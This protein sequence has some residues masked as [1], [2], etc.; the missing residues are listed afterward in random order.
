M[1]PGKFAQMSKN[2]QR[3]FAPGENPSETE[4]QKKVG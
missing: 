1:Y 2:L 4:W 3:F